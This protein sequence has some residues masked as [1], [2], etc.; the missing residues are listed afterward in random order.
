MLSISPVC[1]PTSPLH[2][3]HLHFIGLLFG[4]IPIT[5][6]CTHQILKICGTS[7]L[8]TQI[9]DCELLYFFDCFQEKV[10]LYLAAIWHSS[11]THMFSSDKKWQIKFSKTLI[12]MFSFPILILEVNC[13]LILK[14]GIWQSGNARGTYSEWCNQEKVFL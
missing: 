11:S 3:K 9:P 2:R 12:Y 6:V 5:L 4:S 14:P 1:Q 13:S 8:K 10:G 7:L